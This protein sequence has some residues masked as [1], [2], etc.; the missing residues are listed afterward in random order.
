MRPRACIC[1]PL[2]ASCGLIDPPC[3]LSTHSLTPTLTQPLLNA[4]Q[5]RHDHQCK[6]AFIEREA[7]AQRSEVRLRLGMSSP[8][9]DGARCLLG[10]GSA[11]G[12]G[13]ACHRRW[14]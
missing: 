11:V 2:T 13:S 9:A 1:V 10:F 12:L 14:F 6:L 7:Q 5:A 3:L 4:R 8:K